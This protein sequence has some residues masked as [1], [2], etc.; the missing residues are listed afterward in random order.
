M[1]GTRIVSGL[2][3]GAGGLWLAL[4]CGNGELIGKPARELAAH[5][6]HDVVSK[7]NGSAITAAEVDNLARVGQLS[8]R[9]ALQRLQAE[10]LLAQEAEERGYAGLPWTQR[11][12]RQALVQELLIRDV[13]PEQPDAAALERAY[14]AQQ[15][16]FEQPEQRRATHVLAELRADASLQDAQ[17]ARAFIEKA[18][19]LLKSTSDRAAVLAALRGESTQEMRVLVQELPLA[20]ADGSFVPEFSRALFALPEPG[21]VPEAVR[22]QFGYHAIVV[23]EIV[24]ASSTPKPEALDVLRAELGKNLHEQRVTALLTEL[25]KQTKVAYAQKLESLLGSLE[26]HAQ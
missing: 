26:L 6:A 12:A 18:I 24:R 20:R 21:V 4:A 16:R 11:A 5:D 15:A 22:T 7:V 25:R 3:V 23:T 1:R 9:A 17:A 2:C 8:T 19:A 14:G 13:E 10:R